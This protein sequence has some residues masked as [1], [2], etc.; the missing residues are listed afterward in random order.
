MHWATN[1]HVFEV[2][3]GL[4]QGGSSTTPI[5]PTTRTLAPRSAPPVAIDE[6]DP[7]PLRPSGAGQTD[8]P[9]RR[10]VHA[11]FAASAWTRIQRGEG[12]LGDSAR[13]PAPPP[14]IR[15]MPGRQGACSCSLRGAR[16]P[17]REDCQEKGPGRRVYAFFPPAWP[18]FAG[19]T[20]MVRVGSRDGSIVRRR[21]S[22]T[23]IDSRNERS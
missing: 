2:I 8:Q 19:A 3:R 15:G 22:R 4:T 5:S 7:G 17:A 10:T 14:S 13:V 16:R 18:S 12:C 21:F 9:W 6:E 11:G 1:Q 23:S 20:C